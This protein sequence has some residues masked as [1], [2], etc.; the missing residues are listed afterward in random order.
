MPVLSARDENPDAME[1]AKLTHT[2][3]SPRE[4]RRNFACLVWMGSVFAMGWAEVVVVLQPLLVHYGASNMQIG[5]VQGVL[6]A[7]LPGMFLS[8]W[9]TRRFRYK[10]IYLFVTDSLYLLPVGLVGA[11]VWAGGGGDAAA[12]V[13][14]IVWL[15]LA[16]QIAAGFGGLPNQEFFTACIPMR[17]RGRLAGISAGLGGMLGLIAAGFAAWILGVM[18]QPQ[19]YGVLLVLAWLLCQ[20]ADAAVLFAHEPPTPVEFSP[21]PWG[22]AMWQAFFQ[23]RKFLRVALAVSLIS[24]LL[25]QLAVFSSVFAF[26]ELG[27]KAQMAAW[28]GMTAAGSRLALSPAAGWLTDAWGA[29]PALLLWASLTGLGFLLL[30]LFPATASVFVVVG[31]AAVAGS[32]FA[33]AM[34]ALTS[35]IPRPEHRA[36]HFTLLGF[37]MIGTNSRGPLLAGWIFDAFSYRTGFAVLAAAAVAVIAISYVLLRDLSPHPED[38][39]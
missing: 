19:A 33:G 16:G 7:T 4:V 15:M 2:A 3:L 37:C 8:P 29:R 5:I 34:N 9:I 14:L 24:P 39:S 20:L 27:F 35:G 12:M 36:G 23:D 22:K 31:I 25:G 26:R 21:R 1:A 17:L 6:I 11:A 30:V 13:A 38:Y 32:G 28:L 10:K 18:P